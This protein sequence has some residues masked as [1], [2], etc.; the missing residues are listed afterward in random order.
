MQWRAENADSSSPNMTPTQSACGWKN[1]RGSTITHRHP[2]RDVLQLCCNCC[3]C[4]RDPR[5][6]IKAVDQ[7]DRWTEHERPHPALGISHFVGIWIP[8]SKFFSAFPPLR[9]GFWIFYERIYVIPGMI[10]CCCT[11]VLVLRYCM[12]LDP[13][14]PL[15]RGKQQKR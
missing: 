13:H 8:A 9:V 14:T 12:L 1:S 3:S 4:R 7:V 6:N 11:K 5:Y 10:Y 2:V 15:C